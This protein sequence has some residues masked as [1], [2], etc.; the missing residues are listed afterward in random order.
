MAE[1]DIVFE[2]KKVDID[3][4]IQ[5]LAEKPSLIN[6]DSLCP[7]CGMLLGLKLTLQVIDNMKIVGSRGCV[8]LAPVETIVADNPVA[9]SCAISKNENVLVYAGDGTTK[10]CLNSIIY[11]ARSKCN[12]IYIC[13]NNQGY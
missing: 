8:E 11:A 1:D 6:R 9:V 3:P 10:R 12:V 13:Y 5:E 2:E 4:I 7:G